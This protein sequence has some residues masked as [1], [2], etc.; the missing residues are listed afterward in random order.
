MTNK[1]VSLLEEK[2][3]VLIIDDDHSIASAIAKHIGLRNR[4]VKVGI[5]TKPEEALN[6]LITQKNNNNLPG[7]VITDYDMPGMNGDE[8]VM[9]YYQSNKDDQNRKNPEFW[10]FTGKGIGDLNLTE[11]Q[12]AGFKKII[13]YKDPRRLFVGL[14]EYLSR[15]YKNIGG[16]V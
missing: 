16:L 5:I 9:Q 1:D 8:L 2:V 15:E 11:L 4:E 6:Y 12:N 7:L 14:N 10:L 3:D 13:P